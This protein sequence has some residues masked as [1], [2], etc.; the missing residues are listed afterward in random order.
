MARVVKVGPDA[1]ALA[2]RR[3]VYR[4][5]QWR[6]NLYITAWPRKRGT[7]HPNQRDP[8]E[9]FKRSTQMVRAA[10]AMDI[11]RAREISDHTPFAWRD[12]L[13]MS[14]YGKLVMMVDTNGNVI[15]PWRMYMSVIN[16]LLN[17]LGDAEGIIIY[18][19]DDQWVAL[20]VGAAGQVLTTQGPGAAPSWETLAP[21]GG[22][23]MFHDSPVCAITETLFAG[24][25]RFVPVAV[26]AGT[27]LTGWA[28]WS[29]HTVPATQW[30][31]ATYSEANNT[32]TTLIEQ[33]AKQTG[34]LANNLHQVSF[35][36]PL[37]VTVDTVLWAAI[38]VSDGASMSTNAPNGGI[39]V[40]G[41]T[42][43]LPTTPAPGTRASG[44]PRAAF[45]AS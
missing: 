20:D 33:S 32:P 9:A 21:G 30:A 2:Q 41:V 17:A 40:S 15:G 19:A 34:T 5:M 28:W 38:W 22:A 45:V 12:V 18:R 36:A 11:I 27:T 31:M 42:Y 10:P 35:A 43:P 3:G 4:V 14:Y 44:G 24:H 25:A 7:V 23:P 8:I 37:I 6:G 26:R 39:D 1:P 29:T 13:T 16:D